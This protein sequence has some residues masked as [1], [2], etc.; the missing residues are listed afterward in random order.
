M[1]ILIVEPRKSPHRADIPH[2]LEAMQRIVGGDIE[3]SVPFDDPVAIVCNGEGK[4][5][6]AELN[7]AILGK[8]IIAGTFFLCGVTA[9]SFTDL[10]DDL[11]EK[12]EK[13]FHH[14]EAFAR[15]PMGILV[16]REDGRQEIIQ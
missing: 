11:F 3:E 15:T 13:L 5:Q 4:I 14:P 1:K 16:I 9:E 2:T 6:G 12:Y 8:D 10:P 7:R